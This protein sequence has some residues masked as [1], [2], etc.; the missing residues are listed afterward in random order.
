MTNCSKDFSL[1]ATNLSCC[2]FSSETENVFIFEKSFALRI[3]T[4]SASLYAKTEESTFQSRA[5]TLE[6]IFITGISIS[7]DEIQ[8]GN[9][10][11]KTA[12]NKRFFSSIIKLCFPLYP[13]PFFVNTIYITVDNYLVHLY[14]KTGC[15]NRS[16]K[17]KELI[18]QLKK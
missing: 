17:E 14:D 3:V 13:P 15:S 18:Q 2:T 1:L 9:A 12:D 4:E 10:K 7:F 8:N 6:G 5:S 11:N 16:E